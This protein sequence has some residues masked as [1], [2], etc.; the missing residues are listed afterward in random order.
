MEEINF[1]GE[2]LDK[3]PNNPAISLASKYDK[4]INS[5]SGKILLCKSNLSKICKV[6]RES[7]TYIVLATFKAVHEH[8]NDRK[9]IYTLQKHFY[10]CMR[11]EK[12]SN[13]EV[14]V[15][16]YETRV[17]LFNFA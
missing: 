1:K 13:F 11:I 5:L 2:D 7:V 14:F 8:W 15:K 12:N 3:M 4:N 9:N 16:S 10:I 6:E 17:V